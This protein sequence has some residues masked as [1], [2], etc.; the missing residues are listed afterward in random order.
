VVY[1]GLRSEDVV[2]K[3]LSEVV[4]VLNS[5]LPSTDKLPESIEDLRKAFKQ[6]GQV[7]LAG[8][9]L[10]IS[11]F[12]PR[13]GYISLILSDVTELKNAEDKARYQAYTDIMTGFY[14]RTY[15]EDVMA[16][17]NRLL[18]ELKPISC[19]MIDV[20]G[21]KI[22]NDTFGHA[23]GDDL[24]KSTARII[25]SVMGGV[26]IIS[27]TGGDEFCIIMPDTDYSAAVS[28]RNRLVAEVEEF[29]LKG[30]Q[31][32]INI[33]IGIAT[34]DRSE[35]EDIYSLYKR[36]DDD[37]YQYK[38]GQSSSG[39]SRIIDM[40]QIALAE[41][42][43][44]SEGHVE[45]L[46]EMVEKISESMGLPDMVRRNLVLLAK[47]HDLGK[48]GIPDEILFKPSRLTDEEYEKMKRH[49][50]IG[51]S[52]ASRSKELEHI[53]SFILHHHE[54]W[55]GRGYPAGLRGV[56]IPLECRILGVLD[57]FDAMTSV[58]PYST[59]LPRAAALEEIRRCSGSQF[60]PEV[61]EKFL[62][63]ARAN[64]I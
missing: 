57:S 42:D 26:G 4:H 5:M 17:L 16:R 60:D 22:I 37:M 27:R 51:F 35:V 29:N 1:T 12:S 34:S 28:V 15:F 44:I 48:I 9:W 24:L 39:K 55:D 41:R 30:P 3:L 10:N 21:L 32:P 47:V 43:Y 63:M 54:R 36:A 13:F 20:D 11:S 58:R 45:R 7:R 53:A 50:N 14:N 46:V 56:Q 59:G 49:V 6:Q 8:K 23:S 64:E 62:S 25:V 52:M 31:I 38:I 33:S 61:A 2:G 18:S 40:L 19:V